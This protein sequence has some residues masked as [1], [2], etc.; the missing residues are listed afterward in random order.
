MKQGISTLVITQSEFDCLSGHW[1]V[2]ERLNGDGTGQP[3]GVN[4]GAVG[5]A[6]VLT[7]TAMWAVFFTSQKDLGSEDGLDL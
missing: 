3:F 5:W 1:Q 6:I 4:D 2:D 7:F